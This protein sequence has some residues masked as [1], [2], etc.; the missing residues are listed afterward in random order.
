MPF[1]FR[2]KGQDY[3]R[4]ELQL[5]PLLPCSRGIILQTNSTLEVIHRNTQ[6]SHDLAFILK[7]KKK[8]SGFLITAQTQGKPYGGKCWAVSHQASRL[9][10]SRHTAGP[11]TQHSVLSPL[12]RSHHQ[13]NSSQASTISAKANIPPLWRFSVLPYHGFFPALITVNL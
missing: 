1:I 2:E 7:G 6:K 13:A 12:I 5:P 3:Y 4:P 10:L 11:I 8:H 9:N